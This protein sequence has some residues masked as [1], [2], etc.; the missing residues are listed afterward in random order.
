MSTPGNCGEWAGEAR[1]GQ[2]VLGS[3]RG[4]GTKPLSRQLGGSAQGLPRGGAPKPPR[5]AGAWRGGS[6][7]SR[8]R[9]VPPQGAGLAWEGRVTGEREAASQVRAYRRTQ[10]LTRAR[11]AQ[12]GSRSSASRR[13]A[14]RTPLGAAGSRESSGQREGWALQSCRQVHALPQCW[15]RVS[16]WRGQWEPG[17]EMGPRRWADQSLRSQDS[18]CSSARPE[19]GQ[20]QKAPA[21]LPSPV[22]GLHGLPPAP[23]THTMPSSTSCQVLQHWTQ[24]SGSL[25]MSLSLSVT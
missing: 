13:A 2:Q 15:R 5:T 23:E 4:P 1:A 25:T 18:P 14:S 7:K 16:R 3:R 6:S 24:P 17:A 22:P 8:R 19:R 9:R 12:A 11:A 21:L 20:G 10:R